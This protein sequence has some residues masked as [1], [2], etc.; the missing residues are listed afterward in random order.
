MHGGECK[1]GG[2]DLGAW[3]KRNGWDISETNAMSTF[4]RTSATKAKAQA[5][6]SGKGA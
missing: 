1:S 3:L 4:H 2:Y 5:K 6:G